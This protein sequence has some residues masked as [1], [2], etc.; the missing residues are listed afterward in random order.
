[1]ISWIDSKHQAVQMYGKVIPSLHHFRIMDLMKV[2]WA[3]ITNNQM[4]SFDFL[5]RSLK[6]K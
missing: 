6:F 3:F 1:M 4:H 2:I 5:K